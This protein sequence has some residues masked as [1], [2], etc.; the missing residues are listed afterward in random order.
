MRI[1][2]YTDGSSQGNPGPGGYGIIMQAEGTTYKREFSEGFRK[3]TNN[4]MELLAVI[5]AL[6]KITKE[7]QEVLITTDSKYIINAI[8]KKWVFGWEKKQFKGKKNPDLW[9]RFLKVYRKHQVSFQWVKG[10]SLHPE[11]ERCDYLAVQ[12]GKKEV[13]KV[14]HYYENIEKSSSNTLDL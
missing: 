12:A 11:N 2:I 9:L 7:N 5:T 14:D 4:R 13:L 3:T 10:H 6:E 8:E 1:L